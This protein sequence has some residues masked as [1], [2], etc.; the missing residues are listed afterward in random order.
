MGEKSEPLVRIFGVLD[1]TPEVVTMLVITA[2]TAVVCL[3]VRSRLKERPGR[4]QNMLEKAV[5]YLDNFFTD[6]M[7]KKNARKGKAKPTRL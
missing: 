4:L 7:G 3:I 1:I 5:E 6:I 2:I